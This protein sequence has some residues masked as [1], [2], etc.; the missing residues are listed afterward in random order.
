METKKDDLRIRRTYRLL[1]DALMR[2]M[3]KKPFE[4]ISVKDICDEAMVH[5]TTFYTH[6]ED[7]YDLLKY[8]IRELESPFDTTDIT[9]NSLE[10]YRNYCINVARIILGEVEKD[11]DLFI[12]FMR[13]NEEET[14]L[15]NFQHHL[16]IK[17][18]EK[19][20]K[21]QDNGLKL[22][23]PIPF[24]ANFYAG[25]CI[26]VAAWWLENEM[27]LST[28]EMVGYLSKLIC[29]ADGD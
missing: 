15:G 13:K 7:K 2:L 25:A 24:L 9:E 6:F 1:S 14:F 17:I 4:K 11:S 26:S 19:L 27:P 22:S 10:G 12:S 21:C 29:A 16:T 5:R 20:K 8:C 28:N 18:T 3:K 23:A